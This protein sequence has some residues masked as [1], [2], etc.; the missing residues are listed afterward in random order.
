MSA[1]GDKILKHRRR[2]RMTLRSLA[3]K[4]GVSN[5]LICQLETGKQGNPG[6][7]TLFKLARALEVSPLLLADAAFED[8]A[9]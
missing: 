6:V 5:P 3:A 8:I 9:G 1:L 7:A 4:S 2:M